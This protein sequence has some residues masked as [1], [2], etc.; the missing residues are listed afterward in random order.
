MTLIVL[1]SLY[2]TTSFE[3]IS[4]ESYTLKSEKLTLVNYFA[5]WCKPCL[6]EIPELNEIAKNENLRVFGVSYDRLSDEEINALV[7]NYNIKFPLLKTS[8]LASLPLSLPTVLP[9][10][11]LLGPN[12]DIMHVIKGKITQEDIHNLLEEMD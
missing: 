12:G 6:E 2:K 8:S 7:I 1:I 4:G 11:Y 9:T 5:E 10:T 3:T